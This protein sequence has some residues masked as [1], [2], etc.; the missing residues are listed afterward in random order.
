[1]E[2]RHSPFGYQIEVVWTD[3]R[4]AYSKVVKI[5]VSREVTCSVFLNH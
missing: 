1:M 5:M 3:K 2:K 4:A